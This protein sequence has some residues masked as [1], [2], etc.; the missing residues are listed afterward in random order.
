MLGK[1]HY[2]SKLIFNNNEL[3]LHL[4]T[5]LRTIIDGAILIY[6]SS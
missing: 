1:M 5:Y 2:E 3:K 6:R 4:K